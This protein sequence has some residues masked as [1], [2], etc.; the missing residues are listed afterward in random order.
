MSRIGKMPIELKDNIK[1]VLEGRIL[2]VNGPKG[3]LSLKLRPEIALEIGEKE[4]LVKIKKETK[5]A[6]EQYGLART[7]IANM[8]V[9]VSEGF[10]KRLE[11]KG[12]GY[13]AAVEGGKLVMAL[14][15][16]HPT[17]YIPREGIEIK[18]E[19]NTI[20]VSGADKQIVGQTASEIRELKKPEPY[21]GKGIRYEG[22]RVRRKAGKAAVKSG[23]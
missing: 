10:E 17:V 15:F 6:R 9:G 23:E 21:K 7:L 18:V 5:S 16:S 2:K 4:I 14:G 1:T 3:E 19:K 22:E 20:I 12:V 13:R 11:F 8:I